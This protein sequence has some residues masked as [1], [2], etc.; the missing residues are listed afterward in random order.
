MP[1]FLYKYLNKPVSELI[2]SREASDA[3]K[4][5]IS[6]YNSD[7]MFQVKARTTNTTAL[8]FKLFTVS[9][10]SAGSVEVAMRAFNSDGTKSIVGKKVITYQMTGGVLSVLNSATIFNGTTGSVSGATWVVTAQGDSLI[11]TLTGVASTVLDWVAD[12]THKAYTYEAVANIAPQL[13]SATAA[14]GTAL[15]LTFSEALL[16][17]VTPNAADFSISNHTVS[18]VAVSGSTVTLTPGTNM[19]NGET[20]TVSYTPGTKQIQDAT[21]K[22]APSFK[23][24]AVTNTIA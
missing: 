24:V 15:V 7:S 4:D 14:V 18:N 3:I 1:V 6:D 17:S 20:I 11:I 2:L 9:S 13:V 12:V 22:R 23:D 8:P 10:T 16:T 21:G 5:V 19:T